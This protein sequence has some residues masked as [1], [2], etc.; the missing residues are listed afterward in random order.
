MKS[1]DL[2]KKKITIAEKRIQELVKADNLKKLS[3]NKT[4]QISELQNL[5]ERL[6]NFEFLMLP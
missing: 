6:L 3:E 2:I 4:Y 1:Q 5:Q